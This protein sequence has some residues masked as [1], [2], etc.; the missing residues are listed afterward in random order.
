MTAPNPRPNS[1]AFVPLN[2]LI[3]SG[4]LRDLLIHNHLDR[5]D[6]LFRAPSEISLTKPGLEVGR[7]RL[8]LTLRDAAGGQHVCYLK[9]YTGISTRL[10]CRISKSSK[11]QI[12][13]ENL[14]EL[15]ARGIPAPEPIAFG[16]S[17]T[18]KGS[19]SALLMRAAP[20][21]SLEQW[22]AEDLR[23]NGRA[24]ELSKRLAV[25]IRRFHDTG[26]VHRDMYLCHVFWDP[27]AATESSLHLIDVQRVTR[28]NWRLMRW[29]V[30][31]LAALNY[32]ASCV[33]LSRSR[34]LDFLK[35]YLGACKLDAM[36]RRLAYRIAGKTMQI[37][38][39][40]ARRTQRL[41]KAGS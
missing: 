34:R 23:L 25:L 2:D 31:D 22:L 32:S 30:K 26:F 33:G 3:V 17:V 5:V 37:E 20:G 11:A 7:E 6:A 1:S 15:N 9:R 16:Q 10:S 12:E 40:D 4:K 29:I 27:D 35:E 38:R 39:H 41:A 8:R 36:A 28:P 19:R 24:R 13:W 14:C 18:P 21:R